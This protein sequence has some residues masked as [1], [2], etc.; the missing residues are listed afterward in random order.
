MPKLIA[1]VVCFAKGHRR[2]T[3]IA[4]TPTHKLF[5]C[6]RCKR[7]TRYRKAVASVAAP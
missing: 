5:H 2:G 1:R 3:P 7:V 6:P 4:E